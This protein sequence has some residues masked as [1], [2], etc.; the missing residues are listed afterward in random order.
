MRLLYVSGF[1]LAF[2]AACDV[3]YVN[4]QSADAPC[5]IDSC[6]HEEH[7]D[8][9]TQTCK[10]GCVS[11]GDCDATAC[12]K[13]P[14]APTGTCQA[15]IAQPGEPP[16]DAPQ[17]AGKPI[18]PPIPPLPECP[19]SDKRCNKKSDCGA[20]E[21]CG[22]GVCVKSQ[23]GCACSEPQSNIECGA[24]AHCTDNV[25]YPNAPPFPCTPPGPQQCGSLAHCFEGRCWK[26]ERGA[27][28]DAAV[29]CG[30]DSSCVDGVCN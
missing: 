24:D 9:A 8:A 14:G 27:P 10:P 13:A 25:C 11:E 1:V 2:F 19:A 30:M 23:A 28:C 5:G 6:H 29:H 15:Q 12:V 17:A 7:C 3:T 20:G 22:N 4:P 18:P 21:Q 26:N 16:P